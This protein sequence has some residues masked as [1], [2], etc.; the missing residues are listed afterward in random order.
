MAENSIKVTPAGLEK[1]KAEL[2]YLKG[3]KRMEVAAKIKEALSFGD[4]SEN[5]EY[6]DAKNEQAQLETKIS[7]LEAQ[8]KNVIII[9]ETTETD[10]VGLGLKITMLDIE[11]D[12]EVEYTMV[13]S[14]EADPMNNIISDESPIGK[15]ILGRKVGE[16]VEI[17]APVGKIAMKIVKISR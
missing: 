17:D 9:E 1:M 2:E 6:D 13:G 15:A 7:Q 16:T 8:L 3:P 11:M 5:S 12:E 10:V 14:T 4:I